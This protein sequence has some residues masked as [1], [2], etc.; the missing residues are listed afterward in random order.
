MSLQSSLEACWQKNLTFDILQAGNC[1][2]ESCV[3]AYISTIKDNSIS[4]SQGG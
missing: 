3:S 1:R 4:A 2:Q